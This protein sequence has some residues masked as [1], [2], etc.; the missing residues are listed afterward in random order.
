MAIPLH[1]AVCMNRVTLIARHPASPTR[2]WDRALTEN[3]RV[4]FV[5]A[6]PFLAESIRR[7]FQEDASDIGRII[8]DRTGT[9]MQFLH[10]LSNLPGE[11]LGDVLYISREGDSF[12]SAV[13]RGGDRVLYSLKPSDVDFYLETCRLTGEEVAD[14]VAKLSAG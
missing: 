3:S 14:P 10:L 8:V 9:P 13:G 6:L 2:A 12:L 4:I 7:A 11:F 5:D 1:W